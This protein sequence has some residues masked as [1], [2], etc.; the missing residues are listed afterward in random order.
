MK[1]WTNSGIFLPKCAPNQTCEQFGCIYCCCWLWLLFVS[2]IPW[3]NDNIGHYSLCTSCYKHSYT[4]TRYMCLPRT[5][6][7]V[8]YLCFEYKDENGPLF[9]KFPILCQKLPKQR[10]SGFW[11]KFANLMSFWNGWSSFFRLAI[12]IPVISNLLFSHDG[13]PEWFIEWCFPCMK[14][15]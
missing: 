5:Y 10:C 3:V 12:L 4:Y 11:L 8:K 7:Q 13:L 15:V 9:S 2:G 6:I 14:W 1:T